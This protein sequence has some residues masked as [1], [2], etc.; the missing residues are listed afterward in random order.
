MK[1][2][3]VV[4]EILERIDRQNV[5]FIDYFDEDLERIVQEGLRMDQPFEEMLFRAVDMLNGHDVSKAGFD[6]GTRRTRSDGTYEKQNDGSWVKIEEPSADAG[7]SDFEDTDTDEAGPS[8]E[9]IEQEELTQDATAFL[10][11]TPT[12]EII[13]T[14]ESMTGVSAEEMG[15][16]PDEVVNA[17][18]DGASSE[19]LQSIAEE[20]GWEPGSETGEEASEEDLPGPTA[21]AMEALQFLDKQSTQDLADALSEMED[22]EFSSLDVEQWME[23]SSDEQIKDLAAYMQEQ[24]HPDDTGE[25]G[26]PSGRL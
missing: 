2:Q 8:D 7:D 4:K 5:E 13:R 1:Q 20:L 16:D 6:P 19:E 18:L 17:M 23:E 26:E 10:Q 21:S 15:D 25:G 14:F 24:S 3:E 22:Q 12:D 11:D 9:E